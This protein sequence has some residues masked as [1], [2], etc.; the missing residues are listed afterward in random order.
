MFY[1]NGSTAYNVYSIFFLD[2]FPAHS[3]KKNVRKT[4]P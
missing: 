2:S 4:K 3:Q 1:A